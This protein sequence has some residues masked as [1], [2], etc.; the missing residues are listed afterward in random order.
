MKDPPI[1]TVGQ[2]VTRG[3]KVGFV[4]N[5]GHSFGAHVHMEL[6][7]GKPASFYQYPSSG[8]V[9]KIKSV[10]LDPT[11]L[12]SGGFP[13]DFSYYGNKFLQ[14]E[15][16]GRHLGVDINSPN[17]LGKPVYSPVNGRVQFSE[18]VHWVRNWLGKLI[19]S[20][21][22]HG[23]GNHVWIEVDESNPGI[24]F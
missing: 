12:I 20:V 6:T 7:K 24:K 11:N 4:G 5:T 3:T 13:C 14:P 15:P 22:N 10:Y 21:Y 16:G 9:E 23:F 2:Y 17:D 1:A 8:S 19:P 18:G